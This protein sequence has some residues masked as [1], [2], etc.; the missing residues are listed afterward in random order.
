M[1]SESNYCMKLAALY[2]GGKDSTFAIWKALKEG[3]SIECL[4]TIKSL[5]K[6]S[7]MYH[8]PNIHLTELGAEAMEL[9]LIMSETAGEKEKELE[10]LE[11]V[12]SGL[13]GQGRIE[14]MLSGAIASRY[15]KE[16]VDKIA[17][18]LGQESVAPLW[19]LGEAALMEE[20]I[21]AGFK[22]LVVGV[23]AGGLGE[24]WLG[25]ELDA[26]AL[27]ELAALKE[28]FG[29]SLAGEGGEIETLV[30]DCPLYKKKIEIVD[31]EKKWDGVRGELEIKKA[32]LAEK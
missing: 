31:A 14:G 25:R 3:H 20:M 28:K 17:Q 27:E 18:N 7:F 29:L 13:A 8:V 24:E 11:G 15:Q 4:V 12:L 5:N 2:S 1:V 22:V 30:T 19:G 21:L 16:R 26:K 23:Y 10:E 9:P 6:D 32:A